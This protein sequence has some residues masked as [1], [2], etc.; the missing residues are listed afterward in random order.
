MFIPLDVTYDIRYSFSSYLTNIKR[1][2]VKIATKLEWVTIA[3]KPGGDE[4]CYRTSSVA[5]IIP[6]TRFGSDYSPSSL[7]DQRRDCKLGGKFARLQVWKTLHG[8]TPN[9]HPVPDRLRIIHVFKKAIPLPFE[10][11]YSLSFPIS[12]PSRFFFFFF[13]SP[14][15]ESRTLKTSVAI[16]ITHPD[17]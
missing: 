6:P 11:N 17:R 15:A 9:T 13:L 5:I 2:G 4:N 12:L 10:D 14:Y 7:E 1:V 3:T 8:W 16:I